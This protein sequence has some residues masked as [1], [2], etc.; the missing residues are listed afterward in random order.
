M[1]EGIIEGDK[2]MSSTKQAEIMEEI[3]QIIEQLTDLKLR[4]AGEEEE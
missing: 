2:M 4:I 3:E 1:Q